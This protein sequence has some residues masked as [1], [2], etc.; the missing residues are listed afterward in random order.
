MEKI[1]ISTVFLFVV[2]CAS[3]PL[4]PSADREVVFKEKTSLTQAKAF[5]KVKRFLGRNLNDSKASITVEDKDAGI[6]EG[7]LNLD[8]SIFNQ[9]GD[10][11]KY[12]LSTYYSFEVSNNNLEIKFQD[13]TYSTASWS[14]LKLVSRDK[15]AKVKNICLT[16]LKNKLL[17]SF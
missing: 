4:L 17:Q 1:Y 9:T 6:I 12:P 14:Y 10:F 7:N 11:N 15:V 3:T 8:C 16:P 2:A 13:L 5:V